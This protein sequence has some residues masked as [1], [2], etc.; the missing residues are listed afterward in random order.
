MMTL[1]S[2]P[3]N[4]SSP[5][6]SH[7]ISS[8]ISLDRASYRGQDFSAEAYREDDGDEEIEENDGDTDRDAVVER[9]A[10]FKGTTDAGQGQKVTADPNF[11]LDTANNQRRRHKL[12]F[13]MSA[14]LSSDISP[15]F[16]RG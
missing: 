4:P 10:L 1:T 16:R 9:E 11:G 6:Q 3:Q 7:A 2:P 14:I 13:G 5:P 15:K 8:A 12:K